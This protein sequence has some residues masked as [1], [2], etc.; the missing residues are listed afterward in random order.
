M[1][2]HDGK[3]R[4]GRKRGEGLPVDLFG[5]DRLECRLVWLMRAGHCVAP[6]FACLRRR[7]SQI[8]LAS[9]VVISLQ[10]LRHRTVFLG[11]TRQPGE[12]GLVHLRQ[13]RAECQSRL[14][15]AESV[16]LG[17]EGDCGPG[18]G[19]LRAF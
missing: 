1:A 7:Q 18:A 12:G 3:T 19:D 4:R 6:S 16:T 2:D 15:D 11:F 14:A 10:N 5:K 13:L 8:N 9:W 17:L